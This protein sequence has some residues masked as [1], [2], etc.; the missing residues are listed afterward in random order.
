MVNEAQVCDR[1]AEVV[2]LAK[3]HQHAFKAEGKIMSV[4]THVER[5][6]SWIFPRESR[7]KMNTDGAFRSFFNRATAG[8]VIRNSHGGWISKFM[9]NIGTCTAL[10]AGL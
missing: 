10:Q 5:E 6:I 9:H 8:G 3:N 1:W 7:C 2:Q 4:R